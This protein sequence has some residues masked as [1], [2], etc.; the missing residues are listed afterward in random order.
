MNAVILAG[1]LGKRLQPFTQV[2]PKPLLPVGESSVLEIQVVSL[3]NHGVT[4]IYIATYYRADY[5]RAF[6]GDG[7][8]HGVR[9][10]YSTEPKPLGT[11]GP[12]TLLKEELTEP[13]LMMNGDILTTLD[14]SA[15]YR[16]ATRKDAD[17]TVVTKEITTPCN[18]GEVTAEGEYILEVEEKPDFRFEIVAGIYVL[19]PPVFEL[20]PE[21]TYY[22]IDNLIKDMLRRGLPVARYLTEDY[23]LDIGQVDDYQVAQEAY[24]EH[25]NDLERGNANGEN[26]GADTG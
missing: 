21:N 9:V 13:F 7:S 25:F 20:I 15:L 11:C 17:L 24:G 5:I 6:L 16:F 14:F 26:R 2:V 3:R 19:K 4:D 22:G 8:A 12:V 1:G 18:F 23:W 10:H